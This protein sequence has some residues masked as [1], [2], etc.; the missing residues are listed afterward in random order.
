MVR[1]DGE[2]PFRRR[3]ELGLLRLVGGTHGRC[4]RP[5]EAIGVGE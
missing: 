5:V 4:A 1:E 3:F 2:V